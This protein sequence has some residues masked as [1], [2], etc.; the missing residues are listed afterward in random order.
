MTGVDHRGACGFAGKR[1]VDQGL[2]VVCV[3]HGHA[4]TTKLPS[5]AAGQTE[6]KTLVSFGHGQRLDVDLA[7]LSGQGPHRRLGQRD[8]NHAM[9]AHPLLCGQAQGHPLL[10]T[11][12]KRGQ[13]MCDDQRQL[14]RIHHQVTFCAPAKKRHKPTT[15]AALSTTKVRATVPTRP[16]REPA[17]APA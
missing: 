1:S 16:I 14:A 15:A 3:Y 17:S 4:I 10:P 6:I 7:E 5:Q 11:Q 12:P 13:H 9:T 8:R 2:R